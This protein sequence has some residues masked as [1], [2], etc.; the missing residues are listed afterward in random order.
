MWP[1]SQFPANLVAFTGEILN[2]KLHFL[3][4]GCSRKKSLLSENDWK[5]RIDFSTRFVDISG[6]HNFGRMVSAQVLMG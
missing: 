4:S 2:E 5:L 6:G 1:N 3:C